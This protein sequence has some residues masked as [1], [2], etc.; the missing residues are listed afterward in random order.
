[1][2]LV[3]GGARSG[4]SRYAISRALALS[5][6]AVT[7]IATGRRGD[8]DFDARIARHRAE[9]PAAWTTIESTELVSAVGA[10]APDTVVLV[11]CLT[12][13]VAA[14]L[15]EKVSL[16]G[17]WPDVESSLRRRLHSV[18]LVSNEVGLGVHPESSI[19]LRFRDD[20]GWINQKAATAADE[21]VFLVAG[22][23][24]HLKSA[25]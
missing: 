25:P 12:L 1:V 19:G 7:F 15:E 23:P 5:G 2:L 24:I 11:D 18:I 22:L 4:K 13:W 6:D 20:L 16:E 10:A 3:L 8:P 9:R 17:V 21:V 14:A